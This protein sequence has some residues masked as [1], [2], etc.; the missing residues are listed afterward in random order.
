MS[1]L[2]DIVLTA[3]I[4]VVFLFPAGLTTIKFVRRWKLRGW[5]GY[6][7]AVVGGG[8]VAGIISGIVGL[9]L[10]PSWEVV[11]K[12]IQL[13]LTLGIVFGGGAA[14]HS[15]QQQGKSLADDTPPSKP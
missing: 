9:L 12:G 5:P 3:F 7:I 14:L 15:N 2:I 1:Q 11:D 6:L 13:G 10:P 4:G 8:L